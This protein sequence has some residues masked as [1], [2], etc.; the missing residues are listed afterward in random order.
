ME[1]VHA[2]VPAAQV[3]AVRAF[4]RFYTQRIGVLDRYLDSDFSL[5]EVRVLYELAHRKNLSASDLV[6]ELGLDAGY[7]SRIL[8]RFEAAGWIARE[9]S[10]ED[11]RRSHLRLTPQGRAAFEPLQQKSR[12]EAA[13]LLGALPAAQRPRLIEALG[14][15]QQLLAPE[16]ERQV[17]LRD[18]RP[19]DMG[20]VVQQ[21]GEIY[22]REYGF[23]AEFE[24]LVAEIA[25]GF[26]RNFDPEWERGWIAEV[27][28]ERAGSVF[29]VRK[30]KTVAQLRL[31]ILKP[32]ARG[33]GLGGRLTDEC[34]AFA[35]AKGYR[36][37]T[38]WTN[39]HLDAARA[40]YRARGFTLVHSENFRAYEQD[41]VSETW[42]LK[43]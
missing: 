8:R 11:A 36:K 4:N 3:K 17:V 27:D 13:A 37:I 7:L 18:P 19:G 26:I 15:V 29:L 14:T 32:E 42:E 28:G 34:I 39:G 43:L 30:S 33:L 23:T 20:W 25:A 9:S 10:R 1:S 6:R 24:A 38:L 2:P 22:A 16:R 35:R 5:T 40:I 12:D 31:L 41:L 21:H